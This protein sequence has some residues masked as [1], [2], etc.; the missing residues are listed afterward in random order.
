[1]A[2]ASWWPAPGKGPLAGAGVC[3]R[4]AQQPGAGDVDADQHE[5]DVEVHQLADQVQGVLVIAAVQPE[6][7]DVVDEQ[8]G[9]GVVADR[10]TNGPD[11]VVQG[12]G[13]RVAVDVQ[14]GLAQCLGRCPD[15]KPAVGDGHEQVPGPGDGAGCE[16]AAD[17]APQVLELGGGPACGLGLALEPAAADHQPVAGAGGELH[18]VVL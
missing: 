18:R 10:V 4:A 13:V 12:G 17:T 3:A 11:Q 2:A 6:P 14:D 5:G 9:R 7:G 15:R 1:V 16:L 8:R